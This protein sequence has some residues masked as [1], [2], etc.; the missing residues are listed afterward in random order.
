MALYAVQSPVITGTTPSYGA[1]ALTDTIKYDSDDQFLIVKNASGASVNVT[2]VVPGT[3]HGQNNPDV[4]VAVG[5]A[6][7]KWIG[8]FTSDMKDA[9][10]IITVTFSAITSVTAALV[11][12]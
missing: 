8:P 1:V 10:N 11:Q 3:K 9:D 7:E 12:L 2:V 6:G 5:A 4:V